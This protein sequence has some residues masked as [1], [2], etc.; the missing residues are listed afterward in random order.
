[1]DSSFY[2]SIINHPYSPLWNK[3]RPVILQLMLASENG[4]QQYNLFDHEFKSINSREK[5]F[6]FELRAF[7]GKAVNDIKKSPTAQDL[8]TMLNMS[9][10]ASELLQDTHF[11][12]ALDRK[13]VL[14]VSRIVAA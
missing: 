13:F 12:F 3:Y 1:M 14:K 5:S 7:K 10:K 9:R 4:P 6:S 11:E 8:L 2:S